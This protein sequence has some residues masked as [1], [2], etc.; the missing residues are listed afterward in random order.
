MSA[1]NETT[2]T[3]R[4]VNEREIRLIGMSRSG[5]HAVARWILNGSR[6]RTCFLNCCEGR[7]NPF[8]TARPLGSG[9]VA[10]CHDPRFSL[11]SERCGR[12][13]RKDLL[14]LS[15]EDS[16]L[17][18]ACSDEY[19]RH[20]DGWVGRS[21]RRIDVLLLRDPF[22]L[23]ASRLRRRESMMPIASSLRIWKQ[24]AREHVGARRRYLRHDPVL[25]SYNRWFASAGYRAS[26]ARR[27]GLRG[28]GAPLQQ[29]ADCLGGSSFD[30]AA[31]DG[32]A[33][34][35]RVLERWR[36]MMHDPAF[37]AIFDAETIE[38]ARAAFGDCR[39]LGPWFER[40]LSAGGCERTA[41]GRLVAAA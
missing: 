20:H 21:R 17:A 38:L 11:G 34:E 8:E 22:N 5:N 32:R 41:A 10:E 25:L 18:R 3:K 1:R 33:S 30:G 40:A 28:G 4:I 27:L 24:H 35:M 37:R 19:E 26:V 7:S 23:F 16:F 12:F 6:G 14:L 36:E 13:S 39:E 2:A 29:V 15:H 31:Y 9:A